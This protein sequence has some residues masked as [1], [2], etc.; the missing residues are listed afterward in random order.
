[1][2]YGWGPYSGKPYATI[3]DMV[4]ASEVLRRAN[5]VNVYIAEINLSSG[6][7]VRVATEQ[8]ASR[9]TDSRPNLPFDGTLAKAPSFTVSIKDST[10]FGG[11]STSRGPLQINNAS[12]EYDWLFEEAVDGALITV[13]IVQRWGSYDEGIVIYTGVADGNPSDGGE[14]LTINSRDDNKRLEKPVQRIYGG[15]GGLDGDAEAK[16]K[17]VPI[18]LGTPPNVTLQ[19]LDAVKLTYQGHDGPMTGWAHIYDRSVEVAVDSTAN[20]ATYAALIAATITPGRWASCNAEGVIRLGAKPDGTV[21]GTP[22]GG[23]TSDGTVAGSPVAGTALT[24][25]ASLVHWAIRHSE[26]DVIVDEASVLSVKGTQPAPIQYFLGSGDGRSLRRVIDDL[27][28]G[29]GG[30]AYLRSDRSLTLGIFSL[31]TGAVVARFTEKDWYRQARMMELPS[32]Y[33]KPPRRVLAAFDRNF[34]IQSDTDATVDASTQTLRSQ[35]YSVAVSDDTVTM[36]DIAARYPNSTDSEIIESWFE[37]ESDAVDECN[38]QL[39]LRGGAPR[40][41][42]RFDMTEVAFDLNIG[43]TSEFSDSLPGAR[44]G[45]STPQERV[46]TEIDNG[47]DEGVVSV[48][49]FR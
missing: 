24:D 28:R 13:M 27:M 49:E 37:N 22:S 20:Y 8:W 43:D 40:S 19:L 30:Y 42:V 3:V 44:F 36:A 14:T 45:M 48:E 2:S 10:G 9:E 34:T 23:A 18:C 47:Y 38:R 46:T 25:T 29:I 4:F 31:P 17:Y 16:G 21:T 33:A 11:V 41:L 35:P 12:G 1:M 26:A 7:S 32:D 15:T 39:V 5:P 6:E